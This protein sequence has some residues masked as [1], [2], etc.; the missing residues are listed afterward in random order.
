VCGAQKGQASMRGCLARTSLLSIVVALGAC[1]PAPVTSDVGTSDTGPLGDTGPV[2]VNCP[3]S[4]GGITVPDAMS[5]MGPCCYS[6]SN[7]SRLSAPTLRLRYLNIRAP[8]HSALASSAVQ[9]VLNNSLGTEQ[10]NWLVRGMGNGSDGPFSFMTGYGTRDATSGNYSFST[11]S[12]Y[13]PVTLTGTITG[14]MVTSMPD[15][16][17]LIVPVFNTTVTPPVLEVELQ[18]HNIQVQT[19]TFSENRSCIGALAS[20]GFTTAATLSG[21]LTVADTQ[22]SMI[23]VDPVHAQLCTLIASPNLSEPAAGG[24]YCDAAQSTWMVQPDSLCPVAP[25]TG[26]CMHDPGDNSVCHHDGSGTACNAWQ[27]VSDFAAVG[28]NISP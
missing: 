1:N 22:G 26:P 12:R 16:G 18:L 6:A 10:F 19:S 9:T 2:T 8:M 15:T 28:V 23:N 21:Y 20:R 5:Q 13:A 25:A 7:A 17:T 4:Y 3:S 11:M 24:H 27:L 14:E